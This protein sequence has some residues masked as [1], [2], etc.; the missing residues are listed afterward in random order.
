MRHVWCI[1][2]MPYSLVYWELEMQRK[3]RYKVLFFFS[4]IHTYKCVLDCGPAE[5]N[6]SI[7][8][9]KRAVGRYRDKMR[10]YMKWEYKYYINKLGI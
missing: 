3:K 4:Y 7:S 6:V 10:I 9:F 1:V 8:L 2:E 5:N